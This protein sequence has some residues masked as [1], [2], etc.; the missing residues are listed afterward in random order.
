VCLEHCQAALE[1]FYLPGLLRDGRS[2]RGS[3]ALPGTSF[4]VPVLDREE[5]HPAFAKPNV[6]DTQP[7]HQ[8]HERRLVLLQ[9]VGLLIGFRV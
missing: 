8:L 1:S 7:I 6:L 2:A 4:A 5:E 9:V 3:S